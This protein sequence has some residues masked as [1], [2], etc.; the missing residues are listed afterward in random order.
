MSAH[1]LIAKGTCKTYRRYPKGKPYEEKE[2]I[3][4][5]VFTSKERNKTWVGDITYIPTK[6]RFSLSG[7]IH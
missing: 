5:R 3:L 1:G 6:T 7:G 4:N 2:N